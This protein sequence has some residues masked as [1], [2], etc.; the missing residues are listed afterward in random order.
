MEFKKATKAKAKLRCA[1]SGPSG[2]G[3]TFTALRIAKG[4][5]GKIAVADSESGSASKYAD[6]FEFDVLDLSENKHPSQYVKAIKLA[7]EN[8]YSTLIIDSITHAWDEVKKEVEKKT[9]SMKTPNSFMAWAVGNK[10]WQDLDD[11]II[12]SKINVIVTM[13]AKTEYVQEKD[14]RTGKTVPKKIGMAPEVRQGSEYSYDLVLELTHDHV[15]VISKTR[16]NQLDN[17]CEQKPDEKLGEILASWLS[18]GV[19]PIQPINRVANVING[20]I[21][22]CGEVDADGKGS[23][24]LSDNTA[25]LVN[26]CKDAG[27]DFLTLSAWLVRTKRIPEGKDVRFLADDRAQKMLEHFDEV[28]AEIKK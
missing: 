18:D 25:I 23:I 9:M 13:R 28:V 27:V 20:E 21:I 2:S 17:Y 8:G 16:C 4:L 22:N 26:K 12:G 1:V 6:V 10:L 24:Q 5:G 14:E 3:K 19:E 11:A 15:G 7:E